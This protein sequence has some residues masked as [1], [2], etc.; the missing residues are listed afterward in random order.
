MDFRLSPEEETL[1][2]TVEEF[3]RERLIPLEP[4]VRRRSRHFRRQP[5]EESRQIK[6]RSGDTTLHRDNGKS[7]EAG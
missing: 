6:P 4:A 5:V 2:K 7:R 3:V 1:R